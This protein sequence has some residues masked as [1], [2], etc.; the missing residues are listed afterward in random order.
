MEVLEKRRRQRRP[1]CG[2]IRKGQYMITRNALTP[3]NTDEPNKILAPEIFEFFLL[4]YSWPFVAKNEHRPCDGFIQCLQL[5]EWPRP[6]AFALN[7]WSY[8]CKWVAFRSLGSLLPGRVETVAWSLQP[9]IFIRKSASER[10]YE[11]NM[12]LNKIA[13]LLWT[14]NGQ[15]NLRKSETQTELKSLSQLGGRVSLDR[16]LVSLSSSTSVRRE[17]ENKC[18]ISSPG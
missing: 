16:E 13:K 2:D 17:E 7:S 15:L 9:L 6:Y 5:P 10:S 8:S 18:W 14:F 4:T 12:R 3:K 11:K 1:L